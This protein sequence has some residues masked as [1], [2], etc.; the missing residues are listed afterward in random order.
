[1]SDRDAAL[2]AVASWFAVDG[3]PNRLE[4]HTAGH[5]NETWFVTTDRNR[6]YVLQR[7]NSQVFA[8]AAGVVANTGRVIAQIERR[9]PG[10][11][12]PFVT[13]RDGA[14]A[15]VVEGST[16]RMLGFVAG[17]SLTGLESTDQASAAGVAFGRFQAALAGYDRVDHVVPIPRFHQLDWQLERFD[18]VLGHPSPGRA[19]E[20]ANDIDQAQRDRGS[21]MAESLGPR[22]MIHGDGKVTNLLFDEHDRVVAVLDLDTVMYGALSWDFGDLVRSAAA[23]G[24][25]DDP[26]IGFSIERY[27]A[28]AQGYVRGAGDLV[29]RELRAALGAVPAY[30]AY[31]LALRFLIDYLDGDTYFRVAHP[32]H[33]LVRARSQFR[34][35]QLMANA[36]AELDHIA[37]RA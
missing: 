3:V 16:Y 29:T 4:H 25:E 18:E 31:M 26:G 33:N 30:M 17:R 35:F 12:P 8:D 23:L 20:A 1:V 14:A 28:L 22:G 9:A 13:A 15:V 11:V 21:V 36:R 34:L 2:L 24:A 10:L 27:R 37:M 19:D 32:R 6:R 5:I 7:I